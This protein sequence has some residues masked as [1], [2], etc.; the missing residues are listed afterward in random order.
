MGVVVSI[1]IDAPKKVV[2]AVIT[3]IENAVNNISGIKKIEIIK[4]PD[5]SLLGLKWIETREMFG[6]DATETMWVSKVE[7]DSFYETSAYNS[8]CHY[9]T[10][11]SVEELDGGKTLFKMDFSAIPDT[12]VAKLLSPLG[13]MFRGM[14]KK[15]LM[16]DL[17]DIKKVAEAG[18]E[19]GAGSKTAKLN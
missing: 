18:Y 4:K 13:F 8:G 17:E 5:L 9:K 14:I 6:K 3:D 19:I 7:N 15:A 10:I 1:E 12:L 11:L 2:W 16:T